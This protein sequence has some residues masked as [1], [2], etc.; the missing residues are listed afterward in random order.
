MSVKLDL[1]S[2]GDL[3][4]TATDGDDFI[5]LGPGNTA[6]VDGMGGFDTVLLRPTQQS[7]HFGIY[8]PDYF[9]NV[10]AIQG[11][12]ATEHVTID[13]QI[14]RSLQVFDGGGGNDEILVH[15][16]MDSITGNTYDLSQTKVVNA[17]LDLDYLPPDLPVTVKV[18]HR[19]TA[20]AIHAQSESRVT[21]DASESGITFTLA[22][23]NEMFAN[24]VDTIRD[25]SGSYNYAPVMLRNVGEDRYHRPADGTFFID[26]GQDAEV[27]MV[28]G[29]GRLVVNGAG[30]GLDQSGAVTLLDNSQGVTHVYVDLTP[31]DGVDN[32]LDIGTL[33]VAALQWTFEFNED[34]T[35]ETV[36]QVIRKLTS[37]PT[38]LPPGEGVQSDV[39]RLD[40]YDATGSTVYEGMWITRI[41]QAA[42]PLSPAGNS[43]PATDGDDEFVAPVDIFRGD[44]SLNGGAGTDTLHLAGWLDE[45]RLHEVAEFSSIEKVVFNRD[46][47]Y[48]TITAAQLAEVHTIVGG[49]AD[50]VLPNLGRIILVD[51]HQT[52]FDLRDM[53]LSGAYAFIPSSHYST[54][55]FSDKDHVKLTESVL[56]WFGYGIRIRLVGDVFTDEER[57][58]L[59][60]SGVYV[61]DASD[62]G[63]SNLAPVI[64]ELDG[65][66][67]SA[68]GSNAVALDL[69]GDASITDDMRVR[70]LT[71]TVVNGNGHDNLGISTTGS[72]V[73][74]NGLVEGGEIL[75]ENSPYSF[76][77]IYNVSNTSFE[78]LF[79]NEAPQE[80]I[81]SLV[82]AL[83]YA[84]TGTAPLTQREIAIS[85]SDGADK[86]TTGTVTVTHTTDAQV[87]DP[88]GNSAPSTSQDDTFI[89]P[90][91][92]FRGDYSLNGG[93][94]TDTL[95]L[96]ESEAEFD[97]TDLAEFSGFERILFHETGGLLRL[98]DAGFAEVDAI[99][100]ATDGNGVGDI[101]LDGAP[102]ATFDLRGKT[103]TE[104][105]AITVATS[106]ADLIVSDKSQILSCLHSLPRFGLRV[107]LLG[108]TFT[109]TERTQ[110]IE[111]GVA[112]IW[113]DSDN[114]PGNLA[115]VIAGL[116]GD[117]VQARN[118]DA[119]SLDLEANATLSDDRK[120]RKITVT[121]LNGDA[122]DR[123]GISTSGSIVLT[124]GLVEGGEIRIGSVPF[125]TLFNVTNTSFDILING[126]AYPPRIDTLVRALTYANTGDA[127]ETQR[128]IRISVSDSADKTTTATVTVA[129]TADQRPQPAEPVAPSLLEL[130]SSTVRE[131]TPAGSEI[132][133]LSAVDPDTGDR[134]TYTLLDDA[135]GRFAISGDRIVV[136][137]RLKLDYE[138]GQSHAVRV[139]VTDSH[140]LSMQKDFTIAIQDVIAEIVT[141]TEGHDVIRGGL[142]RDVLT[143]RGGDDFLSGGLGNDVLTGGRGK[144]VFLFDQK[145]NRK[146]NLDRVTDYV[147]RDDSIH[148]ERDIFS[149]LARKSPEKPTK[150]SKSFF[151]IGPKAKDK[152]DYLVYND[153]TGKLYY[154]GDGS[155]TKVKA[156]EVA[157]FVNKPKLQYTEFFV[158]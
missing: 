13:A 21:V 84:N 2:T 115:P 106:Y 5:D 110:L 116:D 108:D 95:Y 67:I 3:S 74:P 147:V 96:T 7:N 32:R 38:P 150:I 25:A 69:G 148:L 89:A 58:E 40:L 73:L 100:G 60:E 157:I 79:N 141:G 16:I 10:E 97:F 55:V 149:K 41:P 101:I 1:S 125:A 135:G 48:L 126:Q 133:R 59:H 4:A 65:D 26:E 76:A 11:S 98:D 131:N 158:V 154:D 64:S 117:H 151:T 78:I 130:S 72:I 105:Y 50:D 56:A 37:T 18:G 36:Q 49:L 91:G 43:A 107:K 113:D 136:A 70:K 34:A 145:S 22:E 142:G 102:R 129:H 112:H 61:W 94:G 146:A 143:G 104:S 20:L 27:I 12:A 152:N 19:E 23:R 31:D 54:V 57:A 66:R 123:L 156:V 132:G 83:T 82:R 153:K 88:A 109:E 47:G 124:D 39:V 75:H 71:V 119:V 118:G 30:L 93:A 9:K 134:L 122:N 42:Q 140:G 103:F 138:Q 68:W 121:V 87:L 35:G 99:A 155:G 144:D 90:I 29:G 52:T 6:R 111:R 46:G 24:G 33:T 15:N 8:I 120:I 62:D 85:V 139:R 53:T 17:K 81:N 137:D 128:Q 28:P 63:A 92:I 44:Y 77:H 14:L 127:A 45:H 86:T 80:Y 51:E 114:G